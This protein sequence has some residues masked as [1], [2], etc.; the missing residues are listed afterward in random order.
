MTIPQVSIMYNSIYF[1]CLYRDYFLYFSQ[2]P[3]IIITP[4]CLFPFTRIP[5]RLT[6]VKILNIL[7][8]LVPGNMCALP[9]LVVESSLLA[10]Q[11]K[12]LDI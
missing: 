6:R 10:Q 3:D 2:M 12:I 11:S 8:L 7:L 5:P 9:T 1:Q 4:T